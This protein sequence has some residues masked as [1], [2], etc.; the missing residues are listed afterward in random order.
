MKFVSYIFLILT[1][2][3]NSACATV[4]RKMESSMHFK[5]GKFH[6]TGEIPAKS[7]W[8]FLTMRMSTKWEKWPD[9]REFSEG[10]KPLEKVDGSDIRVTFINHATLLI[11]VGG[12]N[13][14]TDPQYSKRC[15]P[16]SF[17]GPQRVHLPGIPFEKLPKI[18]V[19]VVSHD[20]YDHLDLDTIERLV[21]R[22][23]PKIFVG[24]GVK[25]RINT[26]DNVREMDWWEEFTISEKFKL[27]FVEVQHF[28]GRS[29]WDRNSTLWG[30]FVLEVADRKIYFGGDSGYGG[31]YRQTFERFG[32]MDLS[33][34]PIGAYSPREFMGPVH[35]DPR[36]A[37]QAHKDLKSKKSIGMHFG[38]F[39][40][41]A[42]SIDEPVNLLRKES[43]DADLKE[44][45]F[46]ALEPGQFWTSQ[47]I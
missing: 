2:F 32:A 3:S 34:L 17:L 9:K 18:D 10:K 35:L 33:L 27:H 28:S 39:Q 36:Q 12:Y 41:T 44:N 8:K 11:Q 4:T 30:G 7:F 46:V 42:E 21:K 6:N 45:E 38:T 5:D 43:R 40:L 29:L 19:V 14:L 37:V 16:L 1:L 26:N 24:L 20:H 22:D 13:I 47:G 15:S 23:N 31:H 25:E